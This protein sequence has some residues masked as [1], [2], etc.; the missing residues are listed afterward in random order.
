MHDQ[1]PWGPVSNPIASDEASNAVQAA[2]DWREAKT[3]VDRPRA[4]AQGLRAR[5]EARA[6]TDPVR[7]SESAEP[8]GADSSSLAGAVSGAI[9]GAISRLLGAPVQLC[10]CC[11]T[12]VEARTAF[13]NLEVLRR[14]VVSG[15]ERGAP[16][17]VVRLLLQKGGFGIEDMPR[18]VDWPHGETPRREGRLVVMPPMARKHRRLWQPFLA[19]CGEGEVFERVVPERAIEVNR[20]AGRL[21]LISIA[22]GALAVAL[23]AAALAH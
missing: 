14:S 17:V 4:G 3:V 15:A 5:T 21:V 7:A 1:R 2:C 22:A 19:C 16:N 18:A 8:Y 12:E 23:A 11:P 13:A 20:R 9:S 10:L 6:P